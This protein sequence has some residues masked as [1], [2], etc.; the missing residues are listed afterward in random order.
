MII[1]KHLT[2]GSST[3][4]SMLQTEGPL[5]SHK[6]CILGRLYS[7]SKLFMSLC[8][9]V[10]LHTGLDKDRQRRVRLWLAR[11]SKCKVVFVICGQRHILL[12]ESECRNRRLIIDFFANS[13][14]NRKVMLQKTITKLIKPQTDGRVAECN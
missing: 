9:A 11:S 1:A 6:R 13:I 12:T 3:M 10:H 4:L 8:L 14:G 5:S 7:T 2:A